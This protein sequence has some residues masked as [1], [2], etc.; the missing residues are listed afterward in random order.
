MREVIRIDNKNL[1]DLSFGESFDV[2]EIS[3]RLLKYSSDSNDTCLLE[4]LDI[5]NVDSMGL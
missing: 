3:H 2:R 1:F 5:T 4:L